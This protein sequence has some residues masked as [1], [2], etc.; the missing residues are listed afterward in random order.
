VSD[1][2]LPD[3]G[4]ENLKG[5]SDEGE[6]TRLLVKDVENQNRDGNDARRGSRAEESLAEI[7]INSLLWMKQPG[8]EALKEAYDTWQF[9]DAL[10]ASRVD[11][12]RKQS[13]SLMNEIY[14]L[15][16]FYSVFQGVLLT[17]VAQSNMLVCHNWWTA[18]FL[19]LLA[20]LVTVAGVIQKYRSVLAL[21]KTISNEETSRKVSS[22]SRSCRF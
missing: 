12:K 10:F 1:R 7:E 18:F 22:C 11:K 16:G 15:V 20:S 21:E 17:A 2:P 4:E 6:R 5:P 8:N 14:Q 9:K 19:S 3:G 13:N